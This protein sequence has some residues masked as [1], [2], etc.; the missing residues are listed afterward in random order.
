[1]ALLQ[2]SGVQ[3]HAARGNPSR[4]K[5]SSKE[6]GSQGDHRATS[7][8]AESSP[9]ISH[10]SEIRNP[11]SHF[12]RRSIPYASSWFSWPVWIGTWAVSSSYIVPWPCSQ[13]YQCQ[14]LV[15]RGANASPSGQWLSGKAGL[16]C[17]QINVT[18]DSTSAGRCSKEGGLPLGWPTPGLNPQHMGDSWEIRSW[19]RLP[20]RLVNCLRLSQYLPA[21]DRTSALPKSAFEHSLVT[22]HAKR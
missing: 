8:L 6:P 5:L 15:S 13:P 12:G 16:G 17:L 11:S 14:V 7:G 10:Q 2:N 22:P 1:M 21:V 20:E 18:P 19:T 4:S 9:A 3:A